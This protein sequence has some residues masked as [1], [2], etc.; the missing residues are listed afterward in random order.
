MTLRWDDFSGGHWGTKDARKADAN[1]WYGSNVRYYEDGSVGPR[2][3]LRDASVTNNQNGVVWG[4]YNTPLTDK[5]LV[6]VIGT[7]AYR[8]TA[9]PN[10]TLTALSGSLAATP[11]AFCAFDHLNPERVVMVNPGDKCY[12]VNLTGTN[13][14]AGISN[15]GA[16]YWVRIHRDRVYSS[17]DVG[18]ATPWRVHYS[19]AGAF[20]TWQASNYFDMGYWYPAYNAFSIKNRVVFG[21]QGNGGWWSLTQSPATGSL[22]EIH[23]SLPPD[24][25]T[26]SI[27]DD[28]DRIWFL[29]QVGDARGI[30][31]TDGA[32][33]NADRFDHLR[34]PGDERPRG[35]FSYGNRD[36]LFYE[37]HET[38][39]PALWRSDGVWGSH[40]FGVNIDGPETRYGSGQILMVGGSAAGTPGTYYWLDCDKQGPGFTTDS[41]ARPGDG[42]DTPLDATLDLPVKRDGRRPILK[43]NTMVVSFTAYDWDE[44]STGGV[45]FRAWVRAW[46]QAD[47]TP[48]D[49]TKVTYSADTGDQSTDGTERT[50]ELPVD[51]E[52]QGAGLQPRFDQLVGVK[53]HWVE[54]F[55]ESRGR[56]GGP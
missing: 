19:D 46:D 6:V 17:G 41:W 39:V 55:E 25:Q 53:I 5:Q 54:L 42:T 20:T 1:E 24:R 34:L 43:P 33:W 30:C 56:R 2:P 35:V 10:F 12:D 44:S 31:V 51:S 22:R 47:S 4:V 45:G 9:G 29:T 16:G 14:I 23:H 18:G 7:T 27:V 8:A 50:I 40:T 52:I 13:A 21:R 38:A 3:G 11:D 32:T 48:T 15:S 37:P 28:M 26:A 49:S 36:I